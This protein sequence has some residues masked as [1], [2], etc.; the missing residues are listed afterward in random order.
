MNLIMNARTNLTV[1][2]VGLALIL[3]FLP[4]AAERSF[5]GRPDKVLKAASDPSR[6]LSCDQVARM[7]VADDSTLRLIDVRNET[8]Y[9]KASLPL[10][11]NIPLEKFVKS[12]LSP[13]LYGKGIKNVLYSN[14]ELESGYALAVASG[15]GYGDFY[16]MAGGMNSWYET[17]MNSKFTGESISARENALFETRTKA[18]RLFRELNSMPDSVRMKYLAAR[19]AE[20]KKLDGGCE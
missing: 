3:A 4:P 20:A 7:I 6:F 15:L 2:I 12:D 1:I 9:R 14:G 17:I 5:H 13:V 11:V 19:Q 10:A 18:A 8:D 16:I